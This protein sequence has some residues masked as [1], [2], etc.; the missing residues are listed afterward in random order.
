MR[1]LLSEPAEREAVSLMLP[2]KRSIVCEL[3]EDDR[4]RENKKPLSLEPTRPIPP[5]PEPVP[6][7]P[8]MASAEM[9]MKHEHAA[10]SGEPTCA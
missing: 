1:R 5:T 10:T 3:R 8:P 9:P 4:P 2:V 6:L 7:M